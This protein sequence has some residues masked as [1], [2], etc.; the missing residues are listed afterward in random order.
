MLTKQEQQSAAYFTP[1]HLV[2]VEL[3]Q[4][5]PS[6]S[7]FDV[8]THQYYKRARCL[9]RLHTQPLGIVELE[10]TEN[11]ISADEYAER[12]W[13]TFSKQINE[14]LQQD[15]L[16]PVTRLDARG[17]FNS[18]TPA[19]ITAREEFL[20]RAPFVSVI[21]P[22]HDRPEQVSRCLCSL[23]SLCYPQYEIIIVD[24]AP[25]TNATM[26]LVEQTYQNKVRYVRE[27]R[28]GSSWARNR[29]IVEARGEILVFADDDV[30]ADTYWLVELVRAFSLTDNVACV[31]GAMLPL[32]LETLPQIWLETTGGFNKG[33]TQRLFNMNQH[34]P[35]TPLYPYKAA[36]F[37]SGAGMAFTAAF[38]HSVDGFD[39][40][41]GVKSP[42]CSC[43]DLAVFFQLI[44]RGYT[45]VYMPSAL[46][47]HHHYRD[48]AAL[49]KQTYGYG[50]GLTAYLTKSV[51]DNP[52]LLFDLIPKIPRGLF[53]ALNNH[54]QKKSEV[55][56]NYTKELHSLK[57]KGMLYG[58]FAY[59]WG[60]WATRHIRK[61]ILPV[62]AANIHGNIHSKRKLE[63]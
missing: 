24:N 25:S 10:L 54:S 23:L 21:V 49:R 9:V 7:A 39:P 40:A 44:T 3:G 52:K 43:E 48:Y 32:E 35:Q 1:T 28:P 38:L 31:T 18:G 22:T 53:L 56:Y 51:L 27:N 29:G 55:A 15:G 2:E 50:V 62:V 20:A 6:L 11:G 59:L 60:R 26:D 37:G 5:L 63:A 42:A 46:M 33:F 41:L 13:Y 57:R 16:L 19:C 12:I 58:P 8:Q 45:L 61:A 47:Y 14:H 36:D 30:V 17:I 34:H 4:P